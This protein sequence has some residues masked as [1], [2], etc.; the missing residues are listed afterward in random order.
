MI[1]HILKEDMK[2]PPEVERLRELKMEEDE[3][4]N[5]EEAAVGRSLEEVNE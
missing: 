3:K 4:R 2:A 5:K 1:P